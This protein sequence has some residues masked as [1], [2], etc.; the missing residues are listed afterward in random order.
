[1]ASEASV[2]DRILQAF[3][4][5]V[6]EGKVMPPSLLAR[7]SGLLSMGGSISAADFVKIIEDSVT[8]DA[9]D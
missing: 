7:L 4:E 3:L 5:R 1:M 6:E 2:Q 9:E 8:D